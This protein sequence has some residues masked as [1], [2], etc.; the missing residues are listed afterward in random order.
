MYDADDQLYLAQAGALYGQ[1]AADLALTYRDT[2]LTPEMTS[3]AKDTA[4]LDSL[5]GNGYSRL[6][7]GA[8]VRLSNSSVHTSTRSHAPLA[9]TNIPLEQAKN[10]ARVELDLILANNTCVQGSSL[11][12]QIKVFVRKDTKGEGPVWLGKGKMRI[13][14]FEC[15]NNEDRHM[16]YHYTVPLTSVT[17]SIN[18]LCDSSPDEEGYAKAKEGVHTLPFVLSLPLD[19]SYGIPRGVLCIQ[20][21]AVVRY[22]VMM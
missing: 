6:K 15:I 7:S 14:G 2:L 12:G 8:S 18:L 13:I 4:G 21:K 5:L 22:I 9:V 1:P 3:T 10:Y 20:S 11:R 19:E 17:S 16:F